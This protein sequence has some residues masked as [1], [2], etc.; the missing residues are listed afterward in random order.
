MSPKERT[1][2]IR[3]EQEKQIAEAKA[4]TAEA[5]ARCEQAKVKKTKKD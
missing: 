1:A 4:R 2:K 5:N 3:A